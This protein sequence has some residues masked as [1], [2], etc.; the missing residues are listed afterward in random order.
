[1]Y[2]KRF[3]YKKH[4]PQGEA[5]KEP[6]QINAHKP[7]FIALW[8]KKADKSFNSA[9]TVLMGDKLYQLGLFMQLYDCL[10]AV[11]NL[12]CLIPSNSAPPRAAENL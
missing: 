9:N 1:M 5:G 3:I 12:A 8:G 4:P 2:A 7:L 10:T 11:G 6:I